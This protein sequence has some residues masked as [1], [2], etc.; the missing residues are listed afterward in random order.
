[1]FLQKCE[2]KQVFGAVLNAYNYIY[3]IIVFYKCLT[4]AYQFRMI[5]H[6]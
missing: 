5:S 3:V 6:I 4:T 2:H 1:L